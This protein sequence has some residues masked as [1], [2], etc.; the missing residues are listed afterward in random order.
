MSQPIRIEVVQAWPRRHQAWTLAL[1]DGATVA[2]ALTAC[3][4][5]L[6]D[7]AG[8][9]VFGERVIPAR[10]LADGERVEVLRPLLIDPKQARRLRAEEARQAREA[11]AA[12]VGKGSAG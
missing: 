9:A 11:R 3:G 12:R 2:D 7:D 10:R 4:L 5:V 8:L 6:A 1:P